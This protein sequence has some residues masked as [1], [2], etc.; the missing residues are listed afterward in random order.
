M[1]KLLDKAYI[2]TLPLLAFAAMSAPAVAQDEG[3][4]VPAPTI[5]TNGD[6]IPDAWDVDGDGKPDLWDTDGDGKPDKKASRKEKPAGD[7]E[8]E[9]PTPQ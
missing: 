4:A 9:A 6:N 3:G 8:P 2:S 7:K 5:D 1:S